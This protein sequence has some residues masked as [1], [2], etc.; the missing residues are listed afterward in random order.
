MKI[1]KCNKNSAFPPRPQLV[2]AL[3]GSAGRAQTPQELS[4]RLVQVDWGSLSEDA[5]V[6]SHH[7]DAHTQKMT[8]QKKKTLSKL[9]LEDFPKLKRD[10]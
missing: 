3:T 8:D 2:V 5:T 6:I 4:T 10:H 7:G 1:T 9:A